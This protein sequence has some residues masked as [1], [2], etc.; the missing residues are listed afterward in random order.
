MDLVPVRDGYALVSENSKLVDWL[1]QPGEIKLNFSVESNGPV[2]YEHREAIARFSNVVNTGLRSFLSLTERF[3]GCVT[4]C[5]R[6]PHMGG[7]IIKG[8]C[9][10]HGLCFN[11]GQ[12]VTTFGVEFS[13][14]D[15]LH[16]ADL[17]EGKFKIN[18][19]CKMWVKS[20]WL[21]HNNQRVCY[22]EFKDPVPLA[23]Q[24]RLI[25]GVE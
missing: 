9:T 2:R 20:G 25:L 15:K 11:D 23:E 12:V 22:F 10:A 21:I 13:G 4:E 24:D 6:C 8:Q 14:Q 17:V 18:I 1:Y 16:V 19:L 7:R 3:K 5:G